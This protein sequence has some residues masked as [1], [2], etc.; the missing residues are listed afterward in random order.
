MDVF[1]ARQAILNRQKVLFGYEVLFRAS[2]HS[3]G[4]DGADS[5]VATHHVIANTIFSAGLE[6][7]LGG[8]RAF[9]NFNREL[10]LDG[11]CSIWS[12]EGLVIEILE[13]VEPDDEIVKACGRLRQ[14]GYT[15]AL[16][17][18]VDDPKFGRLTQEAQFIKVDLR[19]TPRAEQKRLVEKYGRPG[20]SM[21]AEKVETLEEFEWALGIGFDY[22][23]GYFFTRPE[24]VRGSQ[25]PSSKLFCLRLVEEAQREE[26]DFDK[27]RAL[28][29]KDV[30]LSY[31]L[32][33][34]TNSAMFPGHAEVRT[35][36]RGLM[37]LG[38]EGIRRWAAI[39]ALPGLAKD[40]PMELA[41]QSLVRARFSER[42]SILGG[43]GGG[44]NWFLLGLFSLLDALLDRRIETALKE[45]KLAPAVE[46]ALL[47]T[48]EE[49]DR[50]AK[51]YA[52]VEKYENGDWDAVT[53]LAD[54]IGIPAAEI[55]AAYIESAQWASEICG[56]AF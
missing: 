24:V 18:F 32:L 42:L 28:I 23:Q 22:F 16:D 20:I 41:I 53:R 31:K 46:S 3:T 9:L 43:F 29:E 11:T 14:D 47:H 56:L 30:S 2:E 12:K 27:L 51:V 49:G 45:I 52:L 33:R 37:V 44:S 10:L 4:Y 21:L 55:G 48:A 54:Q 1:V 50:M 19:S 15:I 34:Y 8:K 39:A 17:D 7:M 36:E 5:S 38:E 13:S 35:I 25:I 26:L 6:G 40:K